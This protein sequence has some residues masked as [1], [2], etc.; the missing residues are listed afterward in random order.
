MEETKEQ[1]DRFREDIFRYFGLGCV[2]FL[3]F[4]TKRLFFRFEAIFE[5]QDVSYMKIQLRLQQSRFLMSN[6]KLLD[7]FLTLKE[8]HASFLVCFMRFMKISAI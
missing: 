6:F 5:Y 7:R 2:M 4:C 3:N 8:D 1:L